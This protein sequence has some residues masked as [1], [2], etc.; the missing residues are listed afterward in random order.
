MLPEFT[1][2]FPWDSCFLAPKNQ[3]YFITIVSV[4]RSFLQFDFLNW[5]IV[6]KMKTVQFDR[7]E[8]QCYG[9]LTDRSLARLP[10]ERPNKQLTETEAVTCTQPMA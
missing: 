3:F 9:V 1:S 10:S 5:E 8:I 2:S 6:K 7:K 4:G